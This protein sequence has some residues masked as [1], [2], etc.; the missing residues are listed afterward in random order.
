MIT[1]HN[2]D[3]TLLFYGSLGAEQKEIGNCTLFTFFDKTSYVRF[4][5]DLHGFCVA[6]VDVIFPKDIVFRSQIQQRYIG[7]GFTEEGQMI[8]YNRKSEMRKSRNGI[9]CYVFNSP[10][11]L[12]MKISGGQRLRFR[13]MYF[14]ESFFRENNV[15]LYD[16]FWEDA[17]QSL[18]CNEIHSP[19]LLSVYRRIENCPLAGDAFQLWMRGQGL[20]AASYL[21]DLMQRYT[22]ASPVYLSEDEIAAVLQAKRL[23]KENIGSVPT[24]LE[25]SKSLQKAKALGNTF[26]HCGW[27]LLWSFLKKAICPLATSQKQLAIMEY[28]ISTIS[29]S[30]DL[31]KR[32][33]QSEYCFKTIRNS[34]IFIGCFHKLASNANIYMFC[35][36]G[37]IAPAKMLVEGFPPSP[38]DR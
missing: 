38:Q 37:R 16:S 33:K 35:D 8:S 7:I 34:V 31:E 19:E 21:L 18:T 28:Q 3:E 24:I 1:I 30:R 12:F 14:Q 29:F 32:R 36:F 9:D 17:K 27:N 23:I 5:G 6:S 20:T 2:I 4:W 13:G 25:L 10:V 11:P 26:G 15:S 22:S